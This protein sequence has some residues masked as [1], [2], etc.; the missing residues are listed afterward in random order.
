MSLTW[1]MN[2]NLPSSSAVCASPPTALAIGCCCAFKARGIPP[3][4]SDFFQCPD[5]NG[6][7]TRIFCFISGEKTDKDS[8]FSPPLSRARQVYPPSLKTLAKKVILGPAV[9]GVCGLTRDEQSRCGLRQRRSEP[10]PRDQL[11][12]D[13]R[14]GSVRLVRAAQ[15]ASARQS[16]ERSVRGGA[17]ERRSAHSPAD[18]RFHGVGQRRA[19]ETGTAKP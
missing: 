5:R 19:Q 2:C 14:R 9:N 12:H 10:G 13:G 16:Q 7:F 6:S 8:A 17:W 4:Y 3:R 15:S 18:E 11:S 1:L